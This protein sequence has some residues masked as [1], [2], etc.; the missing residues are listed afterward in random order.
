MTRRTP[1]LLAAALVLG[2]ALAIAPTG[3]AS[4]AAPPTLQVTNPTTV[5]ATGTAVMTVASSATGVSWTLGD[6]QGLPLDTGTSPV[7][8]GKASVDLTGLDPG[9]YELTVTATN[10]DGT[11]TATG[12]LAV[13]DPL[14]TDRRGSVFG[15]GTHVFETYKSAQLDAFDLVGY[16]L[17]RF[18]VSWRVVEKT[19]GVY[20]FPA[21][22]DTAVHRVIAAGARPELVAN[23]ANPLY[24]EGRTPGSPEALAAFAEFANAVVE[25]Y[26][27]DDIDLAV[28]N[29]YTFNST[30]ECGDTP[31][32]YS[33]MI[34]AVTDRVHRDHPGTPVT[35]SSTV[36]GAPGLAEIDAASAHFY[37]YPDPPE[38]FLA[39]RLTELRQQMDAAPGGAGLPIWLDEFGYPTHI[40]GGTS[41]D[42]QADYAI[43]SQVL[44]LGAGADRLYWYDL[45]NDGWG[46]DVRENQFG[47]LRLSRNGF[48]GLT[49]KP[50]LAAQATV[51]RQL[52]NLDLLGQQQLDP[53][54]HLAR[55]GAPGKDDVRVLWSTEPRTV[56]LVATHPVTVT[57]RFGAQ[58]VLTPA[59]GRVHLAVDGHPV[60]VS[61]AVRQAAVVATPLL[62]FA[63]PDRL[64]VGESGSATI[65][66]DCT[67]PVRCAGLGRSLDAHVQGR[68]AQL[69][70][71]PG[72]VSTAAVQ[73]T[74]PV[75]DGEYQAV[76]TVTGPKGM[77]AALSGSTTAVPAT[78]ISAVGDLAAIDPATGTVR[79]S[80]TNNT[81]HQ[82]PLGTITF[83][84]DGRDVPL[85]GPSVIPAT[86]TVEVALPDGPVQVWADLR[87][88]VTAEVGGRTET[89][90]GSTG[91]GPVQASGTQVSAPIDL[92]EFGRF[93]YAAREWGGPAD[94]SGTVV[95]SYGDGVF[96][97]DAEITDDV[98]QQANAPEN[99]WRSDSVQFAVSDGVPGSNL[100]ESMEIGVALLP[101]GP[102][103]YS[104][105]PLNFGKK[106]I[107][108]GATA[109]VTR[110]GTTTR[111][112]VEVPW[113]SLALDGP[114]AG[115]FGLSLAVND[116]DNDGLGRAGFAEWGSGITA[117][118]SPALFRPVEL[119]PAS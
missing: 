77:F 45:V 46:E 51:I 20:T 47:V 1:G 92:E 12:S 74:A 112:H 90:S 88:T 65:T 59:A 4:A 58:T 72:R 39:Q 95:P 64:A 119:W 35:A 110:D 85:T 106:G 25:H 6:P 105:P 61:G 111:Y 103:V 84:A 10:V 31:E 55:F 37:G 30:S 68:T 3:T 57:D 13:V 11:S 2:G 41:A 28:W 44:A 15:A 23:F 114:P 48:T 79:V 62:S 96:V 40:G 22:L 53:V 109:Q 14:P 107:T 97:L 113:T 7:T 38:T 70:V 117:T 16:G 34:A 75:R 86:S 54:T 49:P 104:F 50:G 89:A 56:A 63:V 9:Y 42:Q 8:A 29:E 116:D 101:D 81:A 83:S 98:F 115:T 108:P 5:F 21:Y 43:R 76:A 66:L 60:F 71:R 80:I 52:G 118:K 18:D 32:C 36:T 82:V 19:K 67:H 87:W 99:L 27:P 100:R 102:V 33:E 17:T 78:V 94:L 91:F 24:D 26:G 69:P 93:T 73:L